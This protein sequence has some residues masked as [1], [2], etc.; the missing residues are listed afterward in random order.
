MHKTFSF[1]PN[2]DHP[3]T[4]DLLLK[5]MKTVGS[6][7][8]GAALR[9]FIVIAANSRDIF[10]GL[11]LGRVHFP[12]PLLVTHNNIHK[13][14]TGSPSPAQLIGFNSQVNGEEI[15]RI[16]VLYTDRSALIGQYETD[17]GEDLTHPLI[18]ILP[19]VFKLS[20]RAKPR[21]R[22]ETY[23][24]SVVPKG[25]TAMLVANPNSR[26]PAFPM[27]V[28]PYPNMSCK[29]DIG[30]IY[31]QLRREVSSWAEEISK[32]PL[33]ALPNGVSNFGV[34]GQ[35]LPPPDPSL[36]GATWGWPAVMEH[37]GFTDEQYKQA[38]RFYQLA[39][40]QLRVTIDLPVQHLDITVSTSEIRQDG[41]TPKASINV[42]AY[43]GGRASKE[44]SS[45]IKAAYRDLLRHEKAPS[46]LFNFSGQAVVKADQR[47]ALLSCIRP[48]T[49]FAGSLDTAISQHDK[50][51]AHALFK[52]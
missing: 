47:S 23:K 1:E 48:W 39:F 19:I 11:A 32:A 41:K 44:M 51:T 38:A 30:T 43:G 42:Y 29:N 28:G 9:S 3:F 40:I 15:E 20:N 46:F 52:N 34:F 17:C 10:P 6:S 4:E 26:T 18:R 14:V 27:L 12:A 22:D 7:I 24:L 25:D 5:P 33:V 31:S 21:L 8:A 13:G 37:T 35:D 45:K 36:E 49:I 50:L 2:R 16:L